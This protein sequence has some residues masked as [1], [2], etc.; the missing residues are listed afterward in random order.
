MIKTL[1]VA[2]T[3]WYL[4]NFKLSLAQVL[5]DAGFEVVMVSPPGD[6]TARLTEK[7][8]RHISWEVGRQTVAPWKEIASIAAL[9]RIYSAEKPDLVQHFTIKPV[10]YGALAAKMSGV[11][12]QLSS[13]TGRGYAFL[14]DEPKAKAIRPFVRQLYR[15]AFSTRGVR[16]IFENEEDRHFFVEGNFI[17]PDR[18][19]LI[20]GVGVDTAIFTPAPEPEGIPVVG[21]VGRMLWDKGVGELVEAARLVRSSLPLKLFLVGEPDE[22]NPTSIDLEV[23]KSWA[24]EGF[25]EWVGFEENVKSVYDQC[26]I[27]ALP[28]Y[29]EG[30]PTVLLEAAACGRAI[31][32]SDIPGCRAVVEDGVN[33]LLV[34]VGD[35][36]A[37]AEALRKLIS[38]NELRRQM[39]TAGRERALRLFTKERINQETLDLIREMLAE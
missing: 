30:V 36:Q 16:V 1:L 12:H 5:R 31:V 32:A 2:N 39:G 24:A 9:R 20:E 14:A 6:Y 21:Y 29:G 23:V 25:V 22:G 33:G 27:V 4:Y 11:R 10:L 3:D 8:F 26:H 7:G 19:R 13:I 17:K 35:T 15:L 38:N 18:T 28:S 37:L 34:P